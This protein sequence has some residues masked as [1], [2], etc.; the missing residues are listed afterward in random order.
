MQNT[1]HHSFS[2]NKIANYSNTHWYFYKGYHF[3]GSFEFKFGLWLE[4][5]NIKFLCHTGVENFKYVTKSGRITYYHPDFY[6]PEFDEFIEI[7][8]Y[9]PEE[10]KEKLAIIKET[11][12]NL[13]LNI[14]TKNILEDMS[15]WDIDRQLKINIEEFRYDLKNKKYYISELKNKI[16]KEQFIKENI[17]ESKSIEKIANELNVSKHL[18][19]ILYGIYKIPKVGSKE[20]LKYRLDYYINKLGKN[21]EDDVKILSLN[22]IDIK[23]KY[24]LPKGLASKIFLRLGLKSKRK[25]NVKLIE[26]QKNK[27][28]YIVCKLYK[29]NQAYSSIAKKLHIPRDIVKQILIDSNN[30]RTMQEEQEKTSLRKKERNRKRRGSLIIQKLENQK[31]IFIKKFYNGEPNDKLSEFF[32]VPVLCIESYI[33]ALNLDK[34]KSRKHKKCIRCGEYIHY[35]GF[36]S[37]YK[38][39]HNIPYREETLC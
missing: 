22:Q 17:G 24:D 7:K 35:Q 1:K 36:G 29:D 3:Q 30:L 2:Q 5:K 15:V 10:A 25:K 38:A 37:H 9:F 23:H 33:K 19:N 14:Y 11:Y 31:E 26:E 12:P 8:G 32:K 6:L 4:S 20:Y 28:K 18:V 34:S 27:F 39:K 16:S 21:I 13:K